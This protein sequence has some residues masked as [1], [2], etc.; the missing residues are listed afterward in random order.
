MVVKLDQ[1]I[2]RKNQSNVL[3]SD[4]LL[5]YL[6]ACNKRWLFHH[7]H[8]LQRR[9]YWFLQSWDGKSYTFFCMGISLIKKSSNVYVRFRKFLCERSQIPRKEIC[10][11]G[12][13]VTT[14]TKLSDNHHCLCE[15]IRA[16]VN[17]AHKG[18]NY[19]DA[20]VEKICLFSTFSR[21]HT[22]W[23]LKVQRNEIK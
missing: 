15:F 16:I 3:N 10:P 9:W 7:F 19:E 23:R 8:S 14:L 22:C 21:R 2:H 17:W 1:W 12:K 20:E 4:C 6:H 13:W 5:G 11:L 18:S